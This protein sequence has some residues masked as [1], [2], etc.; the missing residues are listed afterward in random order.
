[1]AAC[2]FLLKQFDD[3]LLYLNSIKSLRL[4]FPHKSNSIWHFSI[5]QIIAGREDRQ[6]LADIV[7]ILKNT[8]NPQVEQI[9]KVIK[10]WAKD[11]RVP[12]W[13]AS[14]FNRSGISAVSYCDTRWKMLDEMKVITNYIYEQY[15]FI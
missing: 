10:K 6:S 12:V 4:F 11:N 2:F 8:A 13:I 15:I 7:A 14:I 9:V 1:M 3:V 5:L